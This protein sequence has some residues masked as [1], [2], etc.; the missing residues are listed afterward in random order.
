MAPIEKLSAPASHSIFSCSVFYF[1]LS[2]GSISMENIIWSNVWCTWQM[3]ASDIR[4]NCKQT[5]LITEI[6]EQGGMETMERGKVLAAS[7]HQIKWQL[8][9]VSRLNGVRT[10]LWTTGK[11]PTPLWGKHCYVFDNHIRKSAKR[12]DAGI[13][14]EEGASEAWCGQ[15]KTTPTTP[16]RKTRQLPVRHCTTPNAAT[17]SESYYTL[18]GCKKRKSLA[19]GPKCFMYPSWGCASDTIIKVIIIRHKTAGGEATASVD[20]RS[21]RKSTKQSTAEGIERNIQLPCW[22]VKLL[23]C[24]D[25]GGEL[26][27]ALELWPVLLDWPEDPFFH[28]MR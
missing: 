10:V 8:L 9:G 18:K 22:W 4:V 11:I 16:D 27:W 6:S 19:V 14:L 25:A 12:A 24:P 13:T 2:D 15:E 23:P 20:P 28:K 21:S 17:A 1:I 7:H 3:A 26:W 5:L